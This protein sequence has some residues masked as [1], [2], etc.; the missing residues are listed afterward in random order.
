M[1]DRLVADGALVALVSGKPVT[2]SAHAC[3]RADPGDPNVWERVAP[4]V[5]QRLGPV[6]GVVTDPRC[7][8]VVEAVFRPDLDRRGHGGVVVV[9]PTDDL[10]S[11]V[12]A[13]AGTQ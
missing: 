5:E 13:L 3:F 7:A 6:D 12:N 9:A 4:H 8:T 1:A 2:S 11:V 10:A